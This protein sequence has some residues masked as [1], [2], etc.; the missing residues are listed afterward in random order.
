[1][2]RREFIAR[3]AGAALVPC[4]RARA[5]QARKIPRIG[6]LGAISAS[7]YASQVEGF[8]SGLRDL[9]YVD[10][11]NILIEFR[12]AEGSYDRL[13]AF[14]A[15]FERLKVDVLV[16]HGTP[17]TMAAKEATTT[18][19]IVAA[20]IGDPVAT[21]VVTGIA[22]PGGRITGVAH[23]SPELGVKRLEI[24]TQALSPLKRA[25]IL[26]NPDNALG[27][28]VL[29]AMEA[30][31]RSFG[32]EIQRLSV[33][34]PSEFLDAISSLQNVEGLVVVDDG[35][36]IANAR[37]LGDIASE[38]RLPAIGFKEFA[39]GG[40]LLGYGVN[41]PL[42]FRRSAIL[43][44]RILKGARPADLPIEQATNFELIVNLKTA[45]ALDVPIP[46]TLLA[47]ADEVIE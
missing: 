45:R 19:A 2:R 8:L 46:P 4:S 25:A 21:G 14:A 40:G 16:T 33:R 18:I 10:G 30:P 9:G 28:P 6:F 22:R 37:S 3:L 39:Y 43:V 7:G 35:M 31:A 17:G 34:A 44:D 27:H 26:L 12:W 11:D 23:F 41:F 5:Q 32:V 1:M 29:V 36:L 13:V 15:E 38:K 24:L 47:R 20:A 42:M